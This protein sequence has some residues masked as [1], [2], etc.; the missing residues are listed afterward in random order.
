MYDARSNRLFGDGNLL[1]GVVTILVVGGCFL[2]A[3]MI[4]GLGGSP[5]GDDT[6]AAGGSSSVTAALANPEA[7][8][9]AMADPDEKRFLKS[10]LAVAPARYVALQRTFADTTLDAAG[11][12]QAVQQVAFET[13]A[14]N[15]DILT[16][17]SASSLNRLIDGM[18]RELRAAEQSGTRFCAAETYEDIAGAPQAA[19]TTW[20]A[21][22]E[23]ADEAF[24][25]AAIRINA[26]ILDL[27][28]QARANP[29]RHG[30]FSRSDEAALQKA[31]FGVM[32]DPAV[33]QVMMAKDDPEAALAGLNLC[34]VG[35]KALVAL[36]G[37]PDETK[38]RAWS[39]M[40]NHPKVKQAIR[41]AKQR[42]ANS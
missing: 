1:F 5:A 42:A 26:D 21:D 25:P 6:M 3:L 8:N 10:L 23:I 28:R 7:L 16:F 12:M 40:L 31:M 13:I 29:A 14:E 36:R 4:P 38:G 35:A 19:V 32:T 18:T 15:A 39:A 34:S 17:A 9:T 27:I 20:A 33:M 2:G 37:L 11:Q 24:Y 41:S 22:Q 30:L